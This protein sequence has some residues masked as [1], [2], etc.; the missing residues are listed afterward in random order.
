MVG[1]GMRRV[2][3]LYQ[4]PRLVLPSKRRRRSTRKADAE[5]APPAPSCEEEQLSLEAEEAQNDA[6]EAQ[7]DA[8]SSK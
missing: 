1:G 6:E 5:Q 7:G 3:S 8:D 4:R 2:A